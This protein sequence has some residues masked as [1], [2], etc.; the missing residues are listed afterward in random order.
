MFSCWVK[1]ADIENNSSTIV[2]LLRVELFD[3]YFVF[4]KN[5]PKARNDMAQI[6]G[7]DTILNK[8]IST[9][10]FK[11]IGKKIRSVGDN[12]KP[13]TDWYSQKESCKFFVRY[14]LKTEKIKT[15]ELLAE[16]FY[17]HKL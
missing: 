3:D 13:G 12:I 4:Y 6:L 8:R 1:D 17:P 9:E 15:H 5:W 10:E 11:K 7:L 16:Y 2:Y 14:K